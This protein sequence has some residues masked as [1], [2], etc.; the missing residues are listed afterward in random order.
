LSAVA[1]P[2]RALLLLVLTAFAA[3]AGG[4]DE[5]RNEVRF[6]REA[7]VEFA[8]ADVTNW[9]D[10]WPAFLASC[11][12]LDSP[13]SAHR[14]SWHDVCAEASR[15]HVT[16]SEAVRAWV[17]RRLDAYR[18]SS[19]PA[20][21]D[22]SVHTRENDA[23]FMTGY[24]EPVLEG[25]R[26]RSDNF[27][28]PVYG[29]PD[30]VPHLARADLDAMG[31]LHG[32]EIVWLR[33]PLDAFFLEVQ[34]SGRIHLADGAWMR[35]A[36]AA[37]N[38]QPYRSVGHWLVEQGELARDD[39]SMQSIR[40]WAKTHPQRMLEMIEE[41]PRVVFF[42]AVSLDDPLAGPEG[43]LGVALTP[44]VSVAVDRRYLPLGAPLLVRG[45]PKQA[46]GH[47]VAGPL[48]MMVAQDTGGG[49]EGPLRLDCFQ[50]T[51]DAAGE[52]AG[53]QHERAEIRLL[54]P[55]GTAPESLL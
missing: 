39:V 7:S 27:P 53:R 43:S 28:A 50:G 17:L 42:R 30:P 34:G 49:I 1:A 4:T 52:I 13:K 5:S 38:G 29:A 48:R 14:A 33:N 12:V 16:G 24:F 10:A 45:F 9:M 19:V 51:G 37:N 55:K 18:V 44:G 54:V 22:A 15:L 35:V 25:S 20:G 2:A 31:L 21:G 32:Q 40:A 47:V 46:D 36:Y 6:R 41:N 23:G 11:K 8:R 26:E 3:A